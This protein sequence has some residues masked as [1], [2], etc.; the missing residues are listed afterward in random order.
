MTARG[1]ARARREQ[2]PLA[3][4]DRVEVTPSASAYTVIRCVCGTK[5]VV[6][7]GVASVACPRCRQVVSGALI[8]GAS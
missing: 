8:G 7:A 2:V 6:G 1:W 5:V 4:L 3:G